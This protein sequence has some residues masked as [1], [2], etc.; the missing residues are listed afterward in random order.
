MSTWR[1]DSYS[2]QFKKIFII[3]AA[4]RPNIRRIF[5]REFAARLRYHGVA[6]IPS[7]KILPSDKMLD[8]NTILSKIEDQNIDAVLISRLVDKK[9]VS[10]YNHD[11]YDYYSDRYG[12]RFTDKILQVETSLY[13]TRTEKLVWSALSETVLMEEA[14]FYHEVKSFIKVMVKNL[15]KEKLI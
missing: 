15:S 10:T 12:R 13:D 2:R 4:E 6:A 14:D 5:E 1:D 9:T 7:H 8:K 3:G 11:W